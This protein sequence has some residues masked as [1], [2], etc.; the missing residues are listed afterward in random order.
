MENKIKSIEELFG[1]KVFV[2]NL[3]E[4]KTD[5]EIKALF[6]ENGNEITN[7][8][9]KDLKI[10]FSK[11]ANEMKKL[12]SDDLQKLSD[13]ELETVSGGKQAGGGEDIFSGALVGSMLGAYVGTSL[14]VVPMVHEGDLRYLLGGAG[15]GAVAGAVIGG[16][17]GAIVEFSDFDGGSSGGGSAKIGSKSGGDSKKDY[18]SGGLNSKYGVD[19][20]GKDYLS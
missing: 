7:E 19:P 10:A 6:K 8:Q 18:K 3:V 9:L 16:T 2:K 20:W 13:G 14:G 4:A 5:D 15:I 12:S 11:I 17:L 1:D